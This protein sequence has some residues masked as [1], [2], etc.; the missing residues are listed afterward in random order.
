MFLLKGCHDGVGGFEADF[1]R[2][3]G[4]GGC[5]APAG[6]RGIG[7]GGRGGKGEGSNEHHGGK[8]WRCEAVEEN[9]GIGVDSSTEKLGLE[10]I[11]G[12]GVGGVDEVEDRI[13]FGNSRRI[14][15]MKDCRVVVVED[16]RTGGE[17]KSCSIASESRMQ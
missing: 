8:V 2:G 9:G 5:A 16:C 3:V 7:S 15:G 1:V 10:D 4:V 17:L 14:V 11:D 13:L 12:N 6:A